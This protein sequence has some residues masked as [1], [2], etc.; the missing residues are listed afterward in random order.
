VEQ[1]L[2]QV[3]VDREVAR[4]AANR[5]RDASMTWDDVTAATAAVLWLDANEA[6]TLGAELVAVLDRRQRATAQA[7]PRPAGA[8]AVRVLTLL[9]V[10]PDAPG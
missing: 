10:D 2:A 4:F 6:Q 9:S 7:R 5:S 8:R 3:L 1:L